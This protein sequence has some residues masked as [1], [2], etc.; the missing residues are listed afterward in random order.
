[1]TNHIVTIVIVALS[2]LAAVLL[3]WEHV[4]EKRRQLD[5]MI[6]FRDE[7]ADA[8][9]NALVVRGEIQDQLF[10]GVDESLR[11]M[12]VNDLGGLRWPR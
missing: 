8:R 7:L 4:S 2:L 10:T 1:M 6:R 11:R 9:A 12:S 5:A 3:V